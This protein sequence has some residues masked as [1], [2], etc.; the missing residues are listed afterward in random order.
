M[1]LYVVRHGET[2]AGEKGVIAD[3]KAKLTYKG[4][5]QTLMLKDEINKLNIDI[6][7]YSPISRTKQ[8]L[9]LLNLKKNIIVIKDNRLK[10]RNMGIYEN[11]KYNSIDWENFWSYNSETMYSGLE[12]MKSVYKR[13]SDF[14]NELKANKKEERILLI[15]HGGVARAIDWYFNGIDS[16]AKFDCQN[17]KVYKY[18]F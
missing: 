9:K 7:Y 10:E 14:L 15:T 12:T 18:K 2:E 4:I 3:I 6:V 8:T 1:I 11:A 5:K 13:V 16:K 17:C